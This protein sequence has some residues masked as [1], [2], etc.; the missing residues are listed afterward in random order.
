MFAM[1]SE[2]ETSLLSR[3]LCSLH[4]SLVW[5]DIL[6]PPAYL[7]L[8]YNF[9]CHKDGQLDAPRLGTIIWSISQLFSNLQAT[10]NKNTLL[11]RYFY[12]STMFRCI[13]EGLDPRSDPLVAEVPSVKSNLSWCIPILQ[14]HS[15]SPHNGHLPLLRIEIV[16]YWGNWWYVLK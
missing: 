10:Y 4:Q 13:L 3:S 1:M 5:D 16:M 14:A 11:V 12:F 7:R 6:R 15:Q 2:N 8:E 9:M